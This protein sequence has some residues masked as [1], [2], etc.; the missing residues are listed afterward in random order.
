[1]NLVLASG[2]IFLGAELP[3]GQGGDCIYVKVPD[4]SFRH[5]IIHHNDKW[6]FMTLEE[7]KLAIY[8][9]PERIQEYKEQADKVIKW[10][11]E[12]QGGQGV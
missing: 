3:Q 9:S 11:E 5:V 7:E 4:S 12:K 1:M 10:L 8:L 6:S 2:E